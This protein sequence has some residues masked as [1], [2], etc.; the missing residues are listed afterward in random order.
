MEK[1]YLGYYSMNLNR[2]EKQK[3]IYLMK[4]FILYLKKKIK[5]LM[6]CQSSLQIIYCNN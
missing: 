1:L 5:I 2:V 6:N 3:M 4:L